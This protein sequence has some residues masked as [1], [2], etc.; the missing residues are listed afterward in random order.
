M[1]RGR[2]SGAV[3]RALRAYKREYQQKVGQEMGADESTVS[4]IESGYVRT[5][6]ETESRYVDACG[7]VKSLRA[8]IEEAKD[9]LERLLSNDRSPMALA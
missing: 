5:D 1:K 7:G 2:R 6:F 9:L 3:L 8:L 4:R